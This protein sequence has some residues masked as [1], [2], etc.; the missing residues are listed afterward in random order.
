MFASASGYLKRAI[1]GLLIVGA[2]GLSAGALSAHEFKAGSLE[3]A[4]PWSRATV[5]AAKVAAGYFTVTN[6]TDEP[7]RLV[8]ATAEVAEKTEIHQMSMQDGVMSMRPVDGPLEVPAKGELTLEP[9]GQGPGYHLMFMGLK[10]R[11][12][13]GEKFS[14]TLTFEKAGTVAVEFAVESV[15]AK[16]PDHSQHGG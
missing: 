13:D 7:D 16:A 9:G 3:I 4:H 10:R 15:G 11:V 2:T 12:I 8:S 6:P 14:G 5:P 1:A